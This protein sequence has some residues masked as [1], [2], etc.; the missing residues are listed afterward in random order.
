MSAQPTYSENLSTALTDS[1]PV[2]IYHFVGPGLPLYTNPAFRSMFGVEAS[3]HIEAW[4]AQIHP[5]DRAR[6]Q[7][8]WEEFEARQRSHASGLR[9]RYRV[10]DR[11]GEIRVMVETVVPAVGMAG[12]VGTITDVTQLVQ[13]QLELER[14]H[15]ALMSASRQ[16][17]MAEVATNVLHNV[18]NALN[19]VNVS[20]SLLETRLRE[21]GGDRL[22]RVASLLRQQG[23]GLATFLTTERGRVLPEYLA[24]LSTQLVDEQSAALK[25]LEALS[26]T[27]EHIKTIVRMQQSYATR[28]SMAEAVSVPDL[29]ND[30]VRL[31]AAAFERHG[32]VLQLDLQDLPRITVDKHRVVQILVNLISNAKY[33]CDISHR[34][35]KCVTIQARRTETGVSIAVIDNGVGIPAENMTRIFTHGFTTRSTG[36]GFGLHSAALAARELKGSLRAVSDG[37]GCGA[38][39]ILELPLEPPQSPK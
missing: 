15:Q 4:L 39:F 22:G 6:V 37:P 2:A 21:L 19:S 33:A 28:H 7:A 8:E 26:G 25:E 24:Q 36:H 16:A 20:V 5:E 3:Q 17:G 13:T 32:V 14:T 38:T 1:T 31:N 23:E 29:I 34:A 35:E 11:S 30:S 12:F 10:L 18:G 27:L 9:T